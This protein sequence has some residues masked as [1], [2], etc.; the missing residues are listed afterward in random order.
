MHA[1]CPKNPEEGIRYPQNRD[2][3]GCELP[4]EYWNLNLGPLEDQAVIL[5]TMPAFQLL[6]CVFWWWLFFKDLLYLYE[7]TV[8]VFRHTRRGHQLSL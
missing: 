1:W 2:R 7:Y 4:C 8:A 5:I 3:D 6:G